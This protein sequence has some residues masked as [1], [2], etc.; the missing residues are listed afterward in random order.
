MSEA[1]F[2]IPIKIRYGDHGRYIARVDKGSQ[3][4]LVLWHTRKSDEEVFKA[5]KSFFDSLTAHYQAAAENVQQKST[6]NLLDNGG[7]LVSQPPLEVLLQNTRF[8]R[9]TVASD[10]ETDFERSVRE[11]KVYGIKVITSYGVIKYHMESAPSYGQ[12]K[13]ARKISVDSR[14]DLA[15]T[16]PEFISSTQ[17]HSEILPQ[18]SVPS[19]RNELGK[20]LRV[21]PDRIL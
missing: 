11:N 20:V 3:S 5:I 7:H 10:D 16:L 18:D 19:L 4:Y 6:L 2:V 8:K 13:P 14:I 12:R 1:R 15:L 17:K 21:Y 9:T